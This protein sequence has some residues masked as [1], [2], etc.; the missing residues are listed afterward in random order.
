MTKSGSDY[1]VLTLIN[2]RPDNT[3]KKNLLNYIL[4]RRKSKTY[5]L[6]L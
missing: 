5:Q 3:L 2:R 6:L 1:S 4:A